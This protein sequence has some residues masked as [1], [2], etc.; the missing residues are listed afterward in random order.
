M[1]YIVLALLLFVGCVSTEDKSCLC[2]VDKECVCECLDN[3]CVCENCKYNKSKSYQ[4]NCSGCESEF[5]S[6]SNEPITKCP[7]CPM[8]EDEFNKLILELERNQK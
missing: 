2:S 5:V 1:K 7:N 8:T 6:E 4:V 3:E